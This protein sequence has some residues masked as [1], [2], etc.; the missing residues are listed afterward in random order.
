MSDRLHAAI[1]TVP[2]FPEPGIQFKDITPILATPDL[3]AEALELLKAPFSGADVTK[4]VGMES[5]GFWFGVALAERLGAGFI[6]ARKRGKLPAP[7]LS[8]EFTLEYGTDVLEIPQNVIGE[9]DRVLIHDDVIA[10]GGTAAATAR[11]V[12]RTGADVIGFSFLV[13]LTALNGREQLPENIPFR[14]V[15]EV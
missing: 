11:L 9:G 3:F 12:Q 15:I 2:D 7:T 4:V 5:R 6:P 13:E 14:A 8:E 10:T 1:R